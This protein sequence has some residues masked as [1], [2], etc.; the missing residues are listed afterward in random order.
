[1]PPLL[2][3]YPRSNP[4]SPRR[5]GLSAHRSRGAATLL[6]LLLGGYLAV[7]AGL[8]WKQESLLFQPDVLPVD[9]RFDVPADV[10]ELFIDVPGGRLNALHMRLPHPAGVVFYL[11]GNGG[12]LQSWFVRTHDFYRALNVDL[13]MI[14][15]RGY[16][17]STGVNTD[18]AQLMAD[19]QA[20]WQQVAASYEGRPVIFLGRSLG[21]G[22]AAKLAADLPEAR[23]PDLLILVSPYVSMKQQA[24]DMYP[25]VPSSLLRYPLHT[26]EALRRLDGGHTRIL[27]L[28]G[29]RDTLIPY[30]HSEA[31]HA[32]APASSL[33][34]ISGAGHG[35]ISVFP[36]YQLAVQQA[37]REV[38]Q[39]ASATSP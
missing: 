8:W 38:T 21:T 28:H 4:N 16:G 26:D 5:A 6:A 29:D 34:R 33:V 39:A 35:D 25:Y 3:P 23:R 7:L 1:M 30:P 19:V 15:Y 27:L 2:R 22:L 17:K 20:A 18:E 24:A 32:L 9:H 37:I 10:R 13:Y 36:T 31:L 12:S 14:D 11:H